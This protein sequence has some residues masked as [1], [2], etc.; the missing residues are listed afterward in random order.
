MKSV[1]LTEPCPSLV[2]E[3]IM[4]EDHMGLL[5]GWRRYRIEY[6]FEGSSPEGV[7]YLPRHI[8]ADD[9]EEWLRNKMGCCRE[10][11]CLD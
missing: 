8:D 3:M 11:D 6:E 1:V 5:K 9:L 4:N 10:V 2:E 7:V